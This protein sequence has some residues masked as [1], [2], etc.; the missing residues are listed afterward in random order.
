MK[1]YFDLIKKLSF[2]EFPPAMISISI[3][4]MT[5]FFMNSS[6]EWHPKFLKLNS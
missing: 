1:Y 2:S 4:G 3:E 6:N 5:N